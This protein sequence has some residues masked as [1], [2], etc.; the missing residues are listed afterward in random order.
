VSIQPFFRIIIHI[1]YIYTHMYIPIIFHN[2]FH[3]HK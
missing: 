1:N 2:R 3:T